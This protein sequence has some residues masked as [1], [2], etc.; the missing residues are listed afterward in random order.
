M[1][2]SFFSNFLQHHQIPFCN[3][4][5]TLLGGGF[6][7]I[8]TERMDTERIALGYRDV[9]SEYPYAVNVYESDQA[10]NT[11]LRLGL[12]SDVVMIGSAP[13]IFITERLQQEK[14]T[15][16]YSERFFK[17][18]VW[19]LL[20]PRVLRANFLQHS[21]Y[22][23]KECLHMLCASGYTAGDAALIAAYPGR[24]WKW[25]YFTEVKRQ[26]LPELFDSK[27]PGVVKILWVARLLKLKHPEKAILLMDSLKKNGY[28]C[29]LDMIGIGEMEDKV[30]RMVR[31]MGL[32]D[33]VHFLG[34]MSSEKVREHMEKAN[35]F[36]FT[37]DKQ[38]GWGA[39]LNEAM[40]SGCAVL[41]SDAIGSVPFLLQHGINGLSYKNNSFID[42][43]N[44][45]QLLVEDE[46]LRSKL[47][48]AAVQTMEEEW[49][50]GVAARRLIAL[51]EQLLL[52][53]SAAAMELFQHGPCS[54]AWK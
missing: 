32:T 13:D 4:M 35:I 38:E 10:Y 54:R 44:K 28:S 33:C 16:R 46:A 1:K 19:R 6:R 21:R 11:A 20:D 40:N 27:A 49:N 42:L 37:S 47:G 26:H 45:L 31:E 51:S 3:E 24:C 2:I 14:L 22:R 7:F 50:A 5:H 30:K 23:N 53:R 17:R 34:A 9:S 41:A 29:S 15:F 39:V 25:G 8:A 52:N 48:R 43:Y 36:L 12:D 18:G